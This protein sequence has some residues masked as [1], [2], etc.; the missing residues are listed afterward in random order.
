MGE[1]EEAAGRRGLGC[2]VTGRQAHGA[3]WA[4]GQAGG[5][6]AGIPWQAAPASFLGEGPAPSLPGRDGN[7]SWETQRPRPHS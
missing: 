7:H 6:R 3:A 2:T 5:G 4:A 1:T